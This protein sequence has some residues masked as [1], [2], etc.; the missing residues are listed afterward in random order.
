MKYE[1]AIDRASLLEHARK[2]LLC[3]HIHSTASADQP[4]AGDDTL[5]PWLRAFPAGIGQAE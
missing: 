5:A 1:P 3:E 4:A 2:G